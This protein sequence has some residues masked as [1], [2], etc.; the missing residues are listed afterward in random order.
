MWLNSKHSLN[1]DVD[2]YDK[3]GKQRG[4]QDWFEK[5]LWILFSPLYQSTISKTI[6]YWLLHFVSHQLWL[7]C[8]QSPTLN[9][10][11]FAAR[12][13]SLWTWLLWPLSVDLLPRAVLSLSQRYL[14]HNKN[15]L[16]KISEPGF[17]LTLEAVLS[18]NHQRRH[19]G[20]HCRLGPLSFKCEAGDWSAYHS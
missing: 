19:T 7:L 14:W 4:G 10:F 2:W 13:L 9:V 15:L 5:F 16:H 18:F 8:F 6:K 17:A 3:D 1:L 11:D 20:T 12:T